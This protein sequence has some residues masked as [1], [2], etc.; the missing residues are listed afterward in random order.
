MVTVDRT[1]LEAAL[2]G[3][4]SQ[5]EELDAKI[6]EIRRDLRGAPAASSTASSTLKA[7]V[8]GTD[9]R[10]RGLDAAA[11]KRISEAQKKRWAAYKKEHGTTTAAKKAPRKRRTL[12]AEAKKHISE[13]TRKR[14]EAYRAAK[15]GGSRRGRKATKKA[16]SQTAQAAS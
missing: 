1:L 14:W 3:Y 13:A 9:G 12:S 10:R 8:S 2:F 6:N 7:T 15:A 16:A 11:R 4:E 5:K